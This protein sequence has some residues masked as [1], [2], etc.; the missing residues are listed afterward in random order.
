MDE[1]EPDDQVHQSAGSTMRSPVSWFSAP[2]F[3]PVVTFL[4]N[5]VSVQAVQPPAFSLFSLLRRSGEFCLCH[6]KTE[7]LPLPFP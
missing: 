6:L 2:D 7:T 5:D 3:C 4:Q 1:P